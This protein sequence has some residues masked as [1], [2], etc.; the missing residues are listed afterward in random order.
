[1]NTPG[2]TAESCV[3]GASSS[4]TQ[5]LVRSTADAAGHV[6]PAIPISDDEWFQ[7]CQLMGCGAISRPDGTVDC[8]CYQS[9]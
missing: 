1:M 4:F 5:S 3:G 7:M 6:V 9:Q 8:V 2:F